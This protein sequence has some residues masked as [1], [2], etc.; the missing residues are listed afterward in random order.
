VTARARLDRDGA[1]EALARLESLAAAR[2]TLLGRLQRLRAFLS[3]LPDRATEFPLL[4]AAQAVDPDG[5]QPVATFREFRRTVAGFAAERGIDL[6]LVVDGQKRAADWARTWWM[7]GTDAADQELSDLSHAST[8]AVLDTP[9]VPSLGRSERDGK[10]VVRTYFDIAPRDAAKAERCVSALCIRLAS[11]RDFLFEQ[12]S[13]AHLGDDPDEARRRALQAADLVVVFL[14]P[15]YLSW[16]AADARGVGPAVHA[17]K[18][19]VAPL[20]WS[21]VTDRNDLGPYASTLVFAAGGAGADGAGHV[22]PPGDMPGLD[23]LRA[24]PLDD[25]LAELHTMLARLLVSPRAEPPME[26]LARHLAV[27]DEPNPVSARAMRVFLNKGVE[28][29]G[30][31]SGPAVDVVEHL[32]AWATGGDRPYLVV[33]GEY[34]MGKTV[35]TQTLTQTLLS[36]RE[37]DPSVP[38]PIYFDLRLLSSELRTRDAALDELLADLIKH[39]WRTGRAQPSVTPDDVITAVQQR[40]AVVIFDG[41]DEVLVHMSAQ[42]GQGLLRELLRI[43]PP[44]LATAAASGRDAGKVVLTCRTHFFRTVRDQHTFFRAQ[45]RDGVG[46][47]L[48]EA[49]HLLPFDDHQVRA[50][51][52]RT[53]GAPGV[54]RAVDLLRSVHDLAGLA[55]RP[56]SLRLICEQLERLERRI[57]EG[58]PIDAAGLYDELVKSWLERDLG[59]HQF[60]RDH[61]LR[62]MED[63]AA[64]LWRRKARRIDV[65]E[66]E[67]WLRSRLFDDEDLSRWVQLAR[68]DPAVLAEDLRTATFIVRPGSDQFEF[69]HTSLLEYFLARY[70]HRT[71]AAGH[72]GA[73]GL[74]AVSDETLDFLAEIAAATDDDFLRHVAD[75][76]REYRRGVSEHVVR[77]AIRAAERGLA[78]PSLHG[79]H[80]EGAQLGGLRVAPGAALDLARCCLAG[81]DLTDALLHDVCLDDADLSSALLTRAELHHCSLRGADLAGASFDGAILRSTDVHGTTFNSAR[82]DDSQWLWCEGEPEVAGMPGRLVAPCLPPTSPDPATTLEILAGPSGGISSLAWSPG[83]TRLAAGDGEAVHIWNPVSGAQHARLAGDSGWVR[84]LAWSPDGARLAGGSDDGVVWLWGVGE[85]VRLALTVHQFEG[86]A[87]CTVAPDGRPL[88]CGNDVWRW[89][90]WRTHDP[91]TGESSLLAAEHFGPLAGLSHPA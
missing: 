51:L 71:M 73:W 52:E 85:D 4:A 13:P 35:A 76:G 3:G 43:L 36:R 59:K 72:A 46:P 58:R 29:S 66:L 28:P 24:G 42:K 37:R 19:R 15:E 27:R 55:S 21:R 87:W 54:D 38:L 78:R 10:T 77:Y 7:E 67:Q 49:L 82:G 48:Y 84:A 45:D 79:F 18:G 25:A 56:Y 34:G 91:V 17:A 23:R 63:L 68:P 16:S 6:A 53:Q 86:G 80:L 44:Q 22:F 88:G 57:A 89:L 30:S 33:F 20:C 2:P 31:P 26:V 5:T 64:L 69:A 32:V 1:G 81:A 74:P 65:A 62:L 39:A 9:V 83:G 70:L 8:T 90:R 47:D 12:L 75:C 11:D 50:Y 40:R 60:E 14:S 41:L 61:K